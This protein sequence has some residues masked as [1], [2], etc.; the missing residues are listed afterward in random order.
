MLYF[1]RTVS[2]SPYRKVHNVE[3]ISLMRHEQ[4]YNSSFQ[5][6]KL[7]MNL[8]PKV[9]DVTLPITLLSPESQYAVARYIDQLT[10]NIFNFAGFWL[11]LP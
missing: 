11:R 9:N 4:S 8:P 7:H 3:K 1:F 2:S 5:K 6:M 10:Q